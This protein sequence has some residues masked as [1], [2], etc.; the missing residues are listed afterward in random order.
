[1]DKFEISFEWSVNSGLLEVGVASAGA[2][3]VVL[4]TKYGFNI[5]FIIAFVINIIALFSAVLLYK[6][7]V[8]LN[9]SE[10]IY[11]EIIKK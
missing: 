4:A 2:L 5:L 8:K 10:K 3:S 11:S 1:M 7:L 9:H 6:Y